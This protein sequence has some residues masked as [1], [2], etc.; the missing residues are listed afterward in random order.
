MAYDQH[1]TH[2]LIQAAAAHK[3]MPNGEFVELL[4]EQLKSSE[5]HIALL[6][7]ESRDARADLSQTRRELQIEENLHRETRNEL[8]SL[9]ALHQAEQTPPPAEP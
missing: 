8:S 4:V 9:K 3:R 1:K 7:K 6:T 5:E 2:T